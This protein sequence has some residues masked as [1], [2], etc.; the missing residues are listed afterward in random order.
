MV[1]LEKAGVPAIGIAAKSFEKAWQS[2]V[3]GWGQPYTGYVI[4]P[5]ATTGQQQDFIHNMV[6][7][8]IDSI[9]ENLTTFTNS[10]EYTS[11]SKSQV[12]QYT[13]QLSNSPNGLNA[14]NSFL[15][16]RDWTDG[17]P[18]I[19]PTPEAVEQML[20]GT[21]RAPQDIVMIMEPGFG[22]ATVEKVAINA[23]MAGCEPEQ[24]PVV[25][26]TLD[27]LSKPEMNHRDMQ[28]SGHTEA[29]LILV[30]GPLAKHAGIN[31]GTSAMGPGVVNKANT[32]I[33]RALRLCLINIGYCKAGSGDPNFIG[34]P[35]KFGMCISENEEDSPLDPYHVDLGYDKNQSTVTVITVTGP[36]DILDPGSKTYIDTLHNIK[37]MMSYPNAG[38]GDWIR[39]QKTAQ[40][41]NTNQ[42]IPYQGTYHPILL[43]PSRAVVLS[44]A[45]YSKKNVQ[46]WLHENTQVALS[47]I[48]SKWPIPVD[49]RGNWLSHPDLQHLEST[50]GATIPA[51]QT[52]EQYLL[53]ITGGT[54][55]YGHF[56]Y[57]TY[58]IGTSLVEDINF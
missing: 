18:V 14:I 36:A 42:H 20:K 48:Q 28:V 55:H 21:T 2:C 8:Q 52:P 6:D 31:H 50:A 27:C 32:A 13:V 37:S 51:L 29:P 16:E 10:N 15:E 5:H 43:S 33:G 23:V 19:P 41:G 35:T 3:A 11:K 4:I 30:N 26:A 58:G 44:E 49:E 47:D 17:L 46:E 40:V 22:I 45:G 53:Y 7:G 1:T 38:N 39:G 12:E 25:L 54:T 24:F 57:G 34:L 56:F 9:I